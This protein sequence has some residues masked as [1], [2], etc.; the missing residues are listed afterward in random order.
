MD[1]IVAQAMAKWPDVPAV[2][3]WL[4][5]DQRGQWGLQGESITHPAMVSFISRNYAVDERD[6]WYFQNG[7]QRVYVTLAYTPWVLHTTADGQL[8]THTGSRVE[9]PTGAW[10]DED[11][12]F[13]LRFDACIGL[14]DDRDLLHLSTHL[15][16]QSGAIAEEDNLADFT[17]GSAPLWFGWSGTKLSV[18]RIVRSQVASHFGFIPNPE[19]DQDEAMR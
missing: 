17:A 18:G 8:Q 9:Q 15:I 16:T 7:P 19:P 3:G 14:V 5:L 12:A 2:F 6:R 11:G 13:L 4:S 10:M 1:A